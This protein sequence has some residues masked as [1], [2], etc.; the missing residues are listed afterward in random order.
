ML[1]ATLG[2]NLVTPGADIEEV[3]NRL[4]SIEGILGVLIIRDD[5]FGAVGDLP[6]IIRSADPDLKAKVSR[7]EQSNL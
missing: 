7:D 3:L 2:G 6:E 4:V 1:F 5:K